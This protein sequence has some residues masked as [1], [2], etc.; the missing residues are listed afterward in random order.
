MG[1]Y[2]RFRDT[3][4]A[5]PNDQG[6][7]VGWHGHTEN[8]DDWRKAETA[9]QEREGAQA[10]DPRGTRQ[11][12][13]HVELFHP[14]DQA[15]VKAVLQKSFAWGEPLQH[16]GRLCRKDCEYR[17]IDSRFEPLR[18]ED[19][20]ILRWYGVNFDIDDEVR[21]QNHCVWGRAA[22]GALRAAS[23]DHLPSLSRNFKI[24]ASASRLNLCVSSEKSNRHIFQ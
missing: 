14:D 22:R 4:V 15:G 24:L 20:T 11:F 23:E 3:G 1:T 6:R 9:T 8:I 17:W 12:A 13:S 10:A 5:S 2:Q 16:R 7:I 19:A 18:D 21:A